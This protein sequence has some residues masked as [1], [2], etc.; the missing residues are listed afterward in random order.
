M[1]SSAQLRSDLSAN[2]RLMKSDWPVTLLVWSAAWWTNI[3]PSDAGRQWNPVTR[4]TFDGVVAG[5]GNGADRLA[6]GRR[7]LTLGR[8][9]PDHRSRREAGRLCR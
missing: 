3:E 5:V 8:R 4:H 9:G 7:W 2:T 6:S 1:P